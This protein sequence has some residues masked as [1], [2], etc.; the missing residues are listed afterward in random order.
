MRQTLSFSMDKKLTPVIG[1]NRVR[2]QKFN[3]YRDFLQ[4]LYWYKI[5]F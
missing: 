3:D 2:M 5:C 1:K 4:R